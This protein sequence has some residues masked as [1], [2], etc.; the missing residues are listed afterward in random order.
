VWWHGEEALPCPQ[1]LQ[2]VDD[3][4][5]SGTLH[6]DIKLANLALNL[7]EKV[8]ITSPSPSVSGV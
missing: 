8:G 5:A 7:H 6:R 4:H 3:C 1:L 2:A